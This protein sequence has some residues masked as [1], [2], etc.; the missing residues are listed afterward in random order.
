MCYTFAHEAEIDFMCTL[1]YRMVPVCIFGHFSTHRGDPGPLGVVIFDVCGL[2]VSDH[3]LEVTGNLWVPFR[4][5]RGLWSP[6][7]VG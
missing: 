3:R 2:K 5:T 4:V 6:L 7:G 1:V